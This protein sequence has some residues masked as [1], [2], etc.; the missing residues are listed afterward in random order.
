MWNQF[1]G[2]IY[3]NWG[4]VGIGTNYPD[5][6]LHVKGT[7]IYL[8]EE[9]STQAAGL[10]VEDG[11]LKLSVNGQGN[12]GLTISDSYPYSTTLA[13]DLTVGLD[14][15]PVL[16]VW[17]P[18]RSVWVRESNTQLE[19]ERASYSD[20]IMGSNY[21]LLTNPH[22]RDG[23]SSQYD[24]VGSRGD[25][26]GDDCKHFCKLMGFD[27]DNSYCSYKYGDT[28]TNYASVYNGR[29]D[30][31]LIQSSGNWHNCQECGECTCYI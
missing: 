26:G 7:G 29:F 5:E 14:N 13:G 6:S 17:C 1:S 27:F 11:D 4:N 31:Y 28:C 25:G 20:C 23:A 24:I 12:V 30:N 18:P 16:T 10:F 21:V 3:Y 9:S 2:G 19:D 8:E 15:V 22:I